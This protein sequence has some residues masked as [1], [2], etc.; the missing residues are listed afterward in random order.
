MNATA[1]VRI[2]VACAVLAPAAAFADDYE[3]TPTPTPDQVARDG[4]HPLGRRTQP[5]APGWDK[6]EY[7]AGNDPWDVRD[8]N[9]DSMFLFPT[10]RTLRRGDLALGFP[11][12]GGAPDIQYGL[13][14]WLQVGAGYSLIGFTPTA[15][16]GL[17][18]G[19]RVDFS[20]VGGAFLPAGATHPFTA[21]YGGGVLSAGRDEF[22]VHLGYQ[23]VSA[24]GSPFPDYPGQTVQGG[25]GMTGVEIRIA[26]RAKFLFSLLNFAQI[27]APEGTKPVTAFAV[28]PGVRVYG[29]SLSADVGFA[30]GQ[31]SNVQLKR[32]E[33]P[34]NATFALPLFTLRYQL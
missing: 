21:T 8:P 32:T 13:S 18:R 20:L 10:G 25:V 12:P 6:G 16:M 2:L 17:I 14:D 9:D 31:A 26:P 23:Y 24:A 30:V 19:R 28:T 15:R 3:P 5:G 7:R 1:L 4:W 22:R 34:H 27:G 29:K 33:A 11:G